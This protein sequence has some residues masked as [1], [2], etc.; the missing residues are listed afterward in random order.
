MRLMLDAGFPAAVHCRTGFWGSLPT[1]GLLLQ[2]QYGQP[3]HLLRSVLKSV[4][5]DGTAVAGVR[6]G[7]MWSLVSDAAATKSG[8]LSNYC[9]LDGRAAVLLQRDPASFH[10]SPATDAAALVSTWGGRRRV[11][12]AEYMAVVAQLRP[13]VAVALH[14]EVTHNTGNNRTR[15]SISRSLR[16]LDACVAALS[17]TVSETVTSPRTRLLAYVPIL[18]DAVARARA[19]TDIVAHINAANSI[20]ATTSTS[21]SSPA[22]SGPVIVGIVLG[23]LFHGESSAERRHALADVVAKLPPEL[24]RLLPGPRTVLEMFDAVAAGVDIVDS[25][26]VTNLTRH[27]CAAVFRFEWSVA[28]EVPSVDGAVV[29]RDVADGRTSPTAALPRSQ[30]AFQRAVPQRR[31]ACGSTNKAEAAAP[32]EA[33]VAVTSDSSL[34]NLRDVKHAMDAGPLVQGCPCFACSGLDSN[35]AAMLIS[36]ASAGAEADGSTRPVVARGHSRAYIHH[37]QE[38]HEMLG[39]VLLAVHNTS[40]AARFMMRLRSIVA[41]ASQSGH[42]VSDTLAA[43]RAWLIDVNGFSE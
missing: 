13:D 23:G 20:I 25:D 4:P 28:D 32:E 7:H 1:P 6:F 33:S 12:P 3:V 11:T 39:D 19:I 43:Y 15:E 14:D 5:W 30:Y 31:H 29:A 17:S 10:I 2:T 42:D 18:S 9:N 24:V 37:L 34:L 40:H 38:T 41:T 22:D 21:P 26:Y 35:S 27:G 16:W 8:G 36:S